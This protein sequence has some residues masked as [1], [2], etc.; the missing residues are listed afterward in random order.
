MKN[1][2]VTGG[3]GFLGSHLVDK[4]LERY[5]EV[6]IIDNKVTS[7]V[8]ENFWNGKKNIQLKVIDIKN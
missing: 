4:L 5:M 3:L 6:I 1:I 7:T 8:D 2:I